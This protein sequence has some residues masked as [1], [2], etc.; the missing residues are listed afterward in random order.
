MAVKAVARPIL[1]R[2]MKNSF[3]S[4]LPTARSKK[5]SNK[6]ACK[7][8]AMVIAHA[9]P[10]TPQPYLR[11]KRKLRVTLIKTATTPIQKGVLVS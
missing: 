9:K 4:N 7:R 5:K 3:L 6:T 11:I 8:L 2:G 10:N 1:T